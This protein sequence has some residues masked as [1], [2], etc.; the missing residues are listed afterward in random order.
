MA[1][2]YD[3]VDNLS[4]GKHQNFTLNHFLERVKTY[5]SEQF[6]Y[7]IINVPFDDNTI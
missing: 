6:E 2:L 1:T 5:D 4:V 3:I 7:K